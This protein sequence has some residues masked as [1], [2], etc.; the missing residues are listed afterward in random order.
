LFSTQETAKVE[1]KPNVMLD[2]SFD[3]YL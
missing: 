3:K 1:R 2:A